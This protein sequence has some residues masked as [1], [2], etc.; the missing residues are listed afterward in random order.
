MS[1]FR[2]KKLTVLGS[3]GSIG[4]NTLNI[5]RNNTDKYSVVALAAGRNVDLLHKQIMEFEPQLVAVKNETVAKKLRDLLGSASGTEILYGNDGYRRVAA[6]NEA[7]MVVSA[8]AG[9]AGLLPTMA[10]IEAGKD[11]ALANKEAM[12][13]AG[14]IVTERARV[15]GSRI[16]P[17]D[18]E[19]SAI[20]QCLLGHRQQDIRRIIL[21]AS[22]GPFFHLPTEELCHVTPAQALNHPNWNMGEKITID[23][24]SM[25]NKGLEAIEARWLFDVEF[26]NIQIHVHPQSIVHSLVEYIDGSVIAQLGKPDMKLPI[27]YALSFPERTPSME[28]PLNLLTVG[29]LEFFPPDFDKFPNMKLA[30]EAGRQGGTMP[31]VLNAANE[32][33]VQAFIEKR[34]SFPQ[35][36]NVIE[37]ALSRHSIDKIDTIE[38]VIRADIWAREISL[39]FINKM[40]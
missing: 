10:A 39:E 3:T 27:A 8:L 12:V 25:M 29:P 20:F 14:E 31:A 38:D 24:A 13:M 37:A 21:T 15:R 6:A 36:T 9:A 11:I 23:S 1:E 18:S 34:I 17:I 28:A 2:I 19:H 16:L 35:I 33:A 7:D 26:D 5:I 4:V 22:G 32:V 30:Y 40:I